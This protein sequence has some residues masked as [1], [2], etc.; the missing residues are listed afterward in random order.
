MTLHV[1]GAVESG[2]AKEFGT[3]KLVDADGVVSPLFYS[4]KSFPPFPECFSF[5]LRGWLIHADQNLTD[6]RCDEFNNTSTS[7]CI[8]LLSIVVQYPYVYT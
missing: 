7:N 3:Q 5:L 1:F 2:I 4:L 6:I 8:R